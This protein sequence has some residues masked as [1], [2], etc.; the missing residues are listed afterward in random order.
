M[1]T[2]N[3]PVQLTF[4]SFCDDRRLPYLSSVS[5]NTLCLDPGC[6]LLFRRPPMN[7]YIAADLLHQKG[8]H[9]PK[10]QLQTPP[11]SPRPHQVTPAAWPINKACMDPGNNADSCSRRHIAQMHLSEQ[12]AGDTDMPVKHPFAVDQS[13]LA[14]TLEPA[15]QSA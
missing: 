6:L 2:T 12:T 14:Q 4:R 9:P 5:P 3:P 1:L 15:G 7:S 13:G 11:P 8:T 10:T